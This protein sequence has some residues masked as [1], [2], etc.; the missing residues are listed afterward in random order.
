MGSASSGEVPQVMVG[1]MDAAS[2]TISL[3][4]LDPASEGRVFQYSTACDPASK[5]LLRSRMRLYPSL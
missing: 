2:I 1:A 3:S 4:Y 5:P